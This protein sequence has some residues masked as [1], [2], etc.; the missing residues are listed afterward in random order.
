MEHKDLNPVTFQAVFK[1]PEK[2][3]LVRWGDIL[4][5]YLTMYSEKISK[6]KGVFI[7]HIK[8][9]YLGVEGSYIKVNIYKQDIP[10]DL[11]I[12]GQEEL[13]CIMVTVNSLVYG[14]TEEDTT[15]ALDY[16]TDKLRSQFM[17]QSEYYVKKSEHTDVM[18]CG[19][20]HHE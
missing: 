1:L 17:V 3:N 16:V 13:S 4:R 9:F 19:H 5:Y 6:N 12:N 8:A 7:G 10:A 11:T 14:V 20:H 2:T 18:H 15:T